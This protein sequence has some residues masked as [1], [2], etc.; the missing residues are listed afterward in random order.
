MK[1]QYLWAVLAVLLI[2]LFVWLRILPS[3]GE[4]AKL[5]GFKERWAESNGQAL[6][7]YGR[8]VDQFGASIPEATITGNVMLVVGFT[9]TKTEKLLTHSDANGYFNFLGRKGAK[10]GVIPSKAGYEYKYR[11]QSGWTTGYKADPSR[12]VILVMWKRGAPASLVHSIIRSYIPCDGSA[13]GFDLLTGKNTSA[14]GD[15]IIKL[16]RTPVDIVRG[17]PFDWRVTFGVASGGISETDDL[18]PNEAPATGY[19]T[20]ALIEMKQGDKNWSPSLTKNFYFRSRNGQV[21]GRTT[22]NITADFQPPPTVIHIETYAN[23]A[24]SRDLEY[25][26]TKELKF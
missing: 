21:Y 8:V 22:I 19:T 25:D 10:L 18:Y 17:K 5:E 20:S 11:G 6:D 12:P 26:S 4:R 13:A 24:S 15:L 7:F 1:K 3:L 23:P 9:A 14:G 16:E 2:G